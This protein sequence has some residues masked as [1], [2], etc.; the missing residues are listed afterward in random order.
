MGEERKGQLG[1]M[2]ELVKSREEVG[3]KVVEKIK[4]RNQIRDE[5]RAQE[6]EFNDYLYKVRQE[7]KERQW[8]EQQERES[9]WAMEKKQRQADKLDDQPY[10]AEITLVEQTILF[11]KGLIPSKEKEQKTEEKKTVFDNPDNTEVL[12]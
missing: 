8:N 11:C 1:D 6:K 3:A 12:V 9:A 5:F 10:V 2:P 4:E 7:R